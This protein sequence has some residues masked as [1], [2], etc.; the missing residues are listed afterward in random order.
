MHL[1][2]DHGADAIGGVHRAWLR[3]RRQELSV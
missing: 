1:V 3:M 2:D